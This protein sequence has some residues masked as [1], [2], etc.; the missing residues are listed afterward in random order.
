MKNKDLR[1][2]YL[3]LGAFMLVLLQTPIFQNAIGFTNIIGMYYLGD[4]TFKL[5]G[6]ISFIGV[7]IF[8]ISAL[9]LIFNNIKHKES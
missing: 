3:A 8:I 9:K 7:I 2:I 6:I 1:L 4:V 5:V